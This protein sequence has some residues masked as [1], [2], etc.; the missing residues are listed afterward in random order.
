MGEKITMAISM[1]AEVMKKEVN[2]SQ[3]ENHMESEDTQVS[4]NKGV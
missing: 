3:R 2:K 1:I 4:Q